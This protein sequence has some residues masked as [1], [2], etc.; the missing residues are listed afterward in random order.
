MRLLVLLSEE[1][2]PGG[3]LLEGQLA[4]NNAPVALVDD[5]IERIVYKAL[6]ELTPPTTTIGPDGT[7]RLKQTVRLELLPEHL[8]TRAGHYLPTVAAAARKYRVAPD[9]IL[10]VMEAESYFNPKAVS[11][12]GAYGLMQLVPETG[13]AEAASLV[14]GASRILEPEELFD[15]ETNIELGAA[16]LSMLQH[17]Y[18]RDLTDDPVKLAYLVIAGYNCG[19]TRVRRILAGE[20]PAAM[21]A[22]A[23]YSFLRDGVPAETK[24]YLDEVTRRREHYRDFA[25]IS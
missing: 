14:F 25:R 8:R 23:L 22:G 13:G 11:P 3:K 17:A 2:L 20:N 12:A 21:S 24:G 10:A 7:E 5:E 6:D 19:P 4:I 18:F 9:L 1:A 16:Y 15:P